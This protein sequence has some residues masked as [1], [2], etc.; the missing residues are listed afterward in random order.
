MENQDLLDII[1]SLEDIKAKL[2]KITISQSS[3]VQVEK[4]IGWLQHELKSTWDTE[5]IPKVAY[6]KRP[7]Y[8]A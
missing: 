6:K 4:T 3:K 8:T 2:D 7:V 1:I 5:Y